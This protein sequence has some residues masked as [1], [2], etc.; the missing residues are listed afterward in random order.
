[1]TS[2]ISVSASELD[3]SAKASEN[4]LTALRET[5]IFLAAVLDAFLSFSVSFFVLF[6]C[7]LSS[8][9]PARSEANTTSDATRFG[10]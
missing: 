5:D 4:Q 1:M 8:W 2:D 9:A 6:F 7:F 3:I 10:K